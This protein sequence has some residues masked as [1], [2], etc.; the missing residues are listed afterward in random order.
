VTSVRSSLT[1]LARL[2]SGAASHAVRRPLLSLSAL[3][4][5]GVASAAV[6]FLIGSTT[7]QSN[8]LVASLRSA[9]VRSI[10]VR[11][12][13][14]AAPL[15]GGLVN[16]IAD[17]PAVDAAVAL[18]KVRSATT[19]A[20]A[21]ASVT[22]GFFDGVVL[23]EQV[24]DPV[25]QMVTG[26]LA[27]TGEAVVSVDA[28]RALRLAIPGAGALL[29]DDE[30]VG[31]VGAYRATG[32]GAISDFLDRSVLT[33][34]AADASG[35]FSVLLVVREPS[36][37]ERSV[38]AIGRLLAAYGTERYTVDFDDRAG[39]IESLVAESGRAG[40][41]TTAVSVVTIAAL[42]QI[43]VAFLNASLQRREIAR[44]RALGYARRHVLAAI[45]GEAAAL[46]SVAAV[47][48]VVAGLTLLAVRGYDADIGQ[49]AATAGFVALVGAVAA[50]PGG[51][52]GAV[53]DPARILRVP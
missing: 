22:V 14:P 28:A 35:Y 26:R 10:V 20:V 37:V 18:S 27:A 17:L 5:T 40:V 1:V 33:P 51:A 47:I 53:Q 24:G 43:C 21:D 48:G 41:R 49:A 6:V 29:V 44:R 42:I 13:D 25:I 15:P 45:V 2:A 7:S 16:T 32:L 52:L 39:D 8:D 23:T 4:V 38:D 9:D 12:Q 19:A 34:A 30:R 46:G 36:D 11:A 31:V 3:I 50:L